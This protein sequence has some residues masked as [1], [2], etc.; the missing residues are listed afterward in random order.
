[1]RY[2][3]SKIGF[4]NMNPSSNEWDWLQKIVHI[5]KSGSPRA[6]H[7]FQK[8]Q[9]KKKKKKKKI[10]KRFVILPRPLEDFL[11]GLFFVPSPIRLS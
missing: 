7:K 3:E 10:S 8:C 4:G 2:E 9:K 6:N 1:M 5:K 11:C